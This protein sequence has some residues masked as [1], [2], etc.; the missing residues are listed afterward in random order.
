M[1]P[2]K[3]W[4]PALPEN[5]TG[6]Y[7]YDNSAYQPDDVVLDTMPTG[8]VAANGHTK[9][10]PNGQANGTANGQANGT[11]SGEANGH[12]PPEYPGDP[13]RFSTVDRAEEADTHMW[14]WIKM[15]RSLI[16]LLI[17]QISEFSSYMQ[18]YS[19]V[20]SGVKY[21]CLVDLMFTAIWQPLVSEISYFF[22]VEKWCLKYSSFIQVY[23]V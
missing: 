16:Y 19:K 8:K 9:G 15:S 4:G 12:S 1:S 10:H 11:A 21:Q 6:D 2:A 13:T 23:Y 22:N 5:R 7:A 18:I 14:R 20:R 3:T 17:Y